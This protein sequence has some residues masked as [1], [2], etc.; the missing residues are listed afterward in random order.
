MERRGYWKVEEVQLL[1]KMYREGYSMSAISTLIGRNRRS[2]QN[3][4]QQLRKTLPYEEYKAIEISH[5]RNK[6]TASTAIKKNVSE[7]DIPIKKVERWNEE[8]TSYLFMQYSK[9]YYLSEIA[10]VLNKSEG[11]CRSKMLNMRRK[12][13]AEDYI[14]L[15]KQHNAN[16]RSVH[17][18]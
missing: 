7:E 17:S 3:K 14:E 8:D 16:R 5:W 1:M 13:L 12:M 4:Y 2:C 18:S 10:R 6:E 11:S 15:Q 9:G